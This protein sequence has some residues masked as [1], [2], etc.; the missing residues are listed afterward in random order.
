MR[1]FCFQGSVTKGKNDVSSLAPVVNARDSKKAAM[2][3]VVRKN[4]T[5]SSKLKLPKKIK[6]KKKESTNKPLRQ[7]LRV[8][9]LRSNVPKTTLRSRQ[10]R[11]NV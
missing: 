5:N 10:V 7:T 8:R 6:N 1:N 11:K 2:K 3:K 9:Q 4:K